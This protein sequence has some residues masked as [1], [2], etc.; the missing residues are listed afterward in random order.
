[1][2]HPKPWCGC[3]VGRVLRRRAL[4]FAFVRERRE[5]TGRER[6]RER[7]W[8]SLQRVWWLSS[9]LWPYCILCLFPL[10][11]GTTMMIFY[12]MLISWN[13]DYLQQLWLSATIMIIFY[14]YDCLPR[15]RWTWGFVYCDFILYYDH[16]CSCDYYVLYYVYFRSCL[17]Y[18]D[19][20]ISFY[21]FLLS[22]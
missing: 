16:L 4:T 14:N 21:L 3:C 10:L 2:V 11:C 15:L 17:Q 12:I 13:Y 8:V 20:T 9:M 1:M 22:F 5:K 7:L 18:Y 6:E 19:S